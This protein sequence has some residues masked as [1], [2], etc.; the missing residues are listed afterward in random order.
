MALHDLHT[1]NV[2]WTSWP[3]CQAMQLIDDVEMRFSL[4][5]YKQLVYGTGPCWGSRRSQRIDAGVAGTAFMADMF[6][7][8]NGL[9]GG[10]LLQSQ[11]VLQHPDFSSMRSNFDLKVILACHLIVLCSA[12]W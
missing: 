3:E 10:K 12:F 7:M 8:L 6:V 1:K 2:I 4:V 9:F 11:N 5:H